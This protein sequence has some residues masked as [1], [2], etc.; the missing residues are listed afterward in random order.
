[1]QGVMEPQGIKIAVFQN[2]RATGGDFDLPYV[3][4]N[5]DPDG[6]DY[7][8]YPLTVRDSW[9]CLRMISMVHLFEEIEYYVEDDDVEISFAFKPDAAYRM[10]KMMYPEYKRAKVGPTLKKWKKKVMKKRRKRW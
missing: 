7:F 9:I 1:M 6:E 5:F 10:G 2:Q 4:L 3:I 8:E